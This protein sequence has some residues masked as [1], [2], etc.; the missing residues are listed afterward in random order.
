MNTEERLA[1]FHVMDYESRLKHIDELIERVISMD[2]QEEEVRSELNKLRQ[3]RENLAGYLEGVR[4]MPAEEWARE[5]GPMII[6][7]IVAG[8]LEKLVE[9]LE[10]SKETSHE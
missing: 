7:D 3:K 8:R 4:G 6:W 10:F 5:G 9:Y 1:Q 2:N